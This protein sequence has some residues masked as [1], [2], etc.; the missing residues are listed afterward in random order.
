M[1]ANPNATPEGDHEEHDQ[2]SETRLTLYIVISIVAAFVV[3]WGLPKFCHAVYGVEESES[4][5][6]A[7]FGVLEIGGPRFECRREVALSPGDSTILTVNLLPDYAAEA[8]QPENC[9]S[10]HWGD[11]S[12][13][14]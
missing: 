12:A 9:A 6:A 3:A 2:A 11:G 13:G 8:S 4:F 5:L 1:S 10:L 7:V 14:Y